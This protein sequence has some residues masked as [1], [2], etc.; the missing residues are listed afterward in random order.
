MP[1]HCLSFLFI[2]D[3]LFLPYPQRSRVI[4]FNKIRRKNLFS[5]GNS[6]VCSDGSA[7][8]KPERKGPCS[9]GRFLT[10][11]FDQI[12]EIALEL[13]LYCWHIT[14]RW[15]T[16]STW[17]IWTGQYFEVKTNPSPWST[18][19]CGG[20]SPVC[21][22]GSA[23]STEGRR[24]CTGGRWDPVNLYLSLSKVSEK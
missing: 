15:K 7:P 11:N 1:R 8:Q 5:D 17:E 12:W 4:H 14:S 24:P 2:L 16:N 18:P 22:D 23:L 21:P 13:I 9:D 19:T 10:F 6:P 20:A 3:K